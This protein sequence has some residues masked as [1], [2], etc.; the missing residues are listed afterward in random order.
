MASESPFGGPVGDVDR[1][2]PDIGLPVAID[3][4]YHDAV[5][6]DLDGVITDTASLHE[7]AWA[8]LFAEYEFTSADY[9]HF[10]DGKPRYDGV[11]DFLA[12]RGVSL[13]WGAPSDEGDDTVCGLG[14]RKQQLYLAKIADGVPTFESTVTL[15]RRLDELGVG[16]AVYSASRNCERVLES[17]GISGYFAVRV[18]GVTAEELGLPG[19]PDPAMLLETAN[20]LGARPGRCVVVED[21]EAGVTAGRAGGFGLVI[22]VD[23]TGSAR[24]NLLRCGA[25]AVI[26]DLAD[27]TVRAI[28]RRMSTLPDALLSFGQ[29]AG[30]VSARQ[31]ALFFDFDGTLSDIV[32]DPAAATLVR[33]AD[34]ALR[35]L[36]ALCPVAV[37]SGRD[38]ADIRSRIGIPGL[39]YA[40]SHGFE[41][42]AP[43]GT[44]H[45]NATAAAAVP[46]L[47]HAA[48]ELAA[49]LAPIIGVVVEHKRFA[50]AVHYRN[51]APEAAATVTAAVH[52]AGSR[53]G[54]KVTAGRKV[55]ELRPN[56]D[57]DKGKTL[58]WITDRIA[59]A[60]PLLPI[61]IGD[62]LTDE[63]AFDSVLHDGIGI[64]VRHD[65]D[66]DRSTAARLSLSDPAHVREFI[67]RLVDQCDVDRQ[68]LSSP[69]TFTFGG[70]LPE[71][72]RLREALC[73]VGNGYRATR[74]CAPEA[75]AADLHY[76]GT[77][78]A[79][80]Y[81]RLT[82]EIG[83]VTIDN[84]SLV[85]LPNWLSLKF[86]IDGGDWFDIDSADVLTYRQ[87]LDLRQAELTREFRFRDPSGRTSRVV[88]RRIAAM[89][90]PHAC[91]LETTI[92]AED[93]SGT[94]EFRSVIDGDVRN[95]G[96][97]RYRA[98]AS[99]HLVATTTQE[100]S[101]N[102]ALLVCRSPWQPAPACGA[103]GSGWRPTGF[104]STRTAA[105]GTVTC[106][107]SRPE[108][109]SP[110]RRWPPSSPAA[111]TRYP[112]PVTLPDGC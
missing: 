27:V 99:D 15:V 111:I 38:L 63:D 106:S 50:V 59:G 58:E 103:A 37:L 48:G 67:E 41:M 61:Y 101:P 96:V 5:L 55:V 14:N 4:R 94:I 69:W 53:H 34:K 19:K 92:W 17:A 52:R 49:E 75:D 30:V 25:D 2:G 43:D 66:G 70:Y 9:R 13:P 65:E 60:E 26:G 22:G 72:E 109:R 35:S 54:F 1:D 104:S 32:A 107:P 57:W 23:R 102:T 93:W 112:T 21:A 29:V 3:P 7:K 18:D 36:A 62:D 51:A 45:E 110:S 46:V 12:S 84:E 77:Y 83:G 80:L 105:P 82:D 81:N 39:W 28:D 10:I 79:G 16:T 73:T 11:R 68:V 100:L 56:L 31:P 89:H 87:C 33:G 64:V 47:S 85:N 90:L 20:R 76:P 40:G 78:A 98:L 91:A 24:E 8:E 95:G 44:H 42:V 88:Q 108:S 74:G 97:E 71:Q 6:F 86:R